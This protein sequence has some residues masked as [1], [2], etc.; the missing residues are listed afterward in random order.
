LTPSEASQ[1]IRE[2]HSVWEVSLEDGNI[3]SIQKTRNSL[4]CI[5]N[6]GDATT[7]IQIYFSLA[8]SVTDVLLQ[9]ELD[10]CAMA[11][12]GK[13]LVMLP[14]CARTLE[15][16]Y[17]VFESDLLYGHRLDDRN[18]VQISTLVK[19]ANRGFGL[20]VLPSYIHSLEKKSRNPESSLE[21]RTRVSSRD[22][23]PNG[24]EPGPKTLSQLVYMAR[25]FVD[26]L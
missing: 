5:S 13:D 11:Y 18:S 21:S 6:H 10:I 16:G 17:T 22:L 8:S 23:T 1:K 7:N 20:R 12:N 9:I 15:T 26:R 2:I 19:Y 25:S 24:P 3:A 14:R 4:I